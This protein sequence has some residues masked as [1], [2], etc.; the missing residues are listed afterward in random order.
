MVVKASGSRNLQSMFL[1]EG[2]GLR[3]LLVL[4]RARAALRF[5]FCFGRPGELSAAPALKE[6]LQSAVGTRGRLR[7]LVDMRTLPRGVVIPKVHLQGG[8]A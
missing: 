8:G 6:L 2:V 5:R 4:W 1:G 3:A 7:R